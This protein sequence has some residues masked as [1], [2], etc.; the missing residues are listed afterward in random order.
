[1]IC[2]SVLFFSC[3]GDPKENKG[4]LELL[5]SNIS[6]SS[7]SVPKLGSS[8]DDSLISNT[9][10]IVP[11]GGPPL[12]GEPTNAPQMNP[13]KLITNHANPA[14]DPYSIKG[15]LQIQAVSFQT[16]VYNATAITA[17]LGKED[18]TLSSDGNVIHS[19]RYIVRSAQYP[20][21]FT[22]L[23]DAD[24]MYKII[25]VAKNDF[26]IFS[27]EIRIGHPR[28][29]ATAK[30]LPADFGDCATG[31]CIETKRSGSLVEVKAKMNILNLT[32]E[33]QVDVA[34][35]NPS[36]MIRLASSNDF[37]YQGVLPIPTGAYEAVTGFDPTN[38]DYLCACVISLAYTEP[39]FYMHYLKEYVKIH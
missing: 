19:M 25:V 1:M 27:E 28:K 12:P 39:P 20:W 14:D 17:F 6:S 5:I 8:E 23:V 21:G 26:G 9:I 37:Q 38:S 32:E 3:E 16:P 2:L 13:L 35:W 18:M 7:S 10:Q 11:S 33:L 34:V 22:F 4:L 30:N 29:C 15:L 31:H 24:R 36:E